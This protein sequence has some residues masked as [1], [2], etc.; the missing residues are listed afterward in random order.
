MDPWFDSNLVWRALPIV[1]E[2]LPVTLTIFFYSSLIGLLFGLCLAIF[3]VYNICVLNILSVMLVSYARG[4]P[5]LV[6]LI[7]LYYLL[8]IFL[9]SLGI[10]INAVPAL[11]FVIA[12]NGLYLSA[13]FCE[14]FRS[15]LGNV[16]RGQIEA[17]YSI[18]MKNRQV[19]CRV[20]MPQAVMLAIPDMSNIFLVALKSTALAF[21]VGVMDVMGRG[22]TLS[23]QT[24]RSFEVFL[25]I[26]IIYFILCTGMER[27]FKL[28]ER[29]CSFHRLK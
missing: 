13:N 17:A 21:T 24:M 3:R 25:S 14:V 28:V 22:I 8:P 19:F 6:Q 27:I 29:K 7:L 5:V 26:S 18:G 4:T 1:A 2:Y 15:A 10:D 12:A 9:I 23:A 11:Y 16:E 20:M